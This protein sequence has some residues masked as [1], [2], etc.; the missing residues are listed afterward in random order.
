[1]VPAFSKKAVIVTSS[2]GLGALGLNSIARPSSNGLTSAR[3]VEITV[4]PRTIS[5]VASP[6]RSAKAGDDQVLWSTSTSLF[7]LSLIAA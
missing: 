7:Q 6:S 3:A 4:S 5:K 2:L 1:M